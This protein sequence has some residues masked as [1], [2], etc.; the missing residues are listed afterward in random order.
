M[1][2]GHALAEETLSGDAIGVFESF[3]EQVEALGPYG[4]LAFVVTVMFA[5]MVPLLPTQPLSLAGGLLFGPQ[6]GA[7]LVLLGVTLAA[8]NAFLVSRTFGRSVAQKIIASE[9]SSDDEDSSKAS[10]GSSSKHEEGGIKRQLAKVEAAIESGGFWKQAFA[11]MILRLTPV[12]PFSASNYLLG[13]TPVQPAAFIAGTLAGMSAWSIVYASLG[14]ASRK[15]LDRGVDLGKVLSDLSEKSAV[16]T[17]GALIV[18]LAAGGVAAAVYAA[19]SASAASEDGNASL[20]S[21][22]DGSIDVTA[23]SNGHDSKLSSN[24]GGNGSSSNGSGRNG[25]AAKK[26]A[27]D[28]KPA[29]S[30]RP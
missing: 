24:G 18:A 13:L 2:P 19:K 3:L 10:S 20:S 25:T 16:Y 9:V 27:A 12:V 26:E 30:T 17:K 21:R 23:D 28:R 15:L 6:K 1:V 22:A 14:A 29:G 11:V 5:E 7:L 8:T 4:G